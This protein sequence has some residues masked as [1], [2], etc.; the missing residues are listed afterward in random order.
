MVTGLTTG[1]L[2]TV[3]LTGFSHQYTGDVA[4]WLTAP[5][6]SRVDLL[7][8]YFANSGGTI[9]I[10]FE[11]RAPAVPKPPLTS[12]TFR[13]DSGQISALTGPVNGTWSL[14]VQDV[15]SG[16]GGSIASW[17]LAFA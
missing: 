16:G 3:T 12:G 7:Q 4:A 15:Y 9:T 11:D 13:P 17:R 5:D 6:G 14:Y 8:S 2:R 1:T 10:N